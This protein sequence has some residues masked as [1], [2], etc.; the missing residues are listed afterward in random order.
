MDDILLD[1]LFQQ[2]IDSL[3]EIFSSKIFIKNCIKFQSQHFGM[4]MN[5][6]QFCSNILAN[7]IDMPG[8]FSRDVRCT[9]IRQIGKAVSRIGHI[10]HIKFQKLVIITIKSFQ[11]KLYSFHKLHDQIIASYIFAI[12]R[13]A[14][15]QHTQEIL[16]KVLEFF[17]EKSNKVSDEVLIAVCKASIRLEQD[18]AKV[19]TFLQKYSEHKNQDLKNAAEVALTK[20]K[21]FFHPNRLKKTNFNEYEQIFENG[22][23]PIV[24]IKKIYFLVINDNTLGNKLIP[25]LKQYIDGTSNSNRDYAVYIL[26]KLD[27]ALHDNKFIPEIATLCI[28]HL[29]YCQEIKQDPLK[30]IKKAASIIAINSIQYAPQIFKYFEMSIQSFYSNHAFRP[31]TVYSKKQI[32]QLHAE[33]I[34]VNSQDDPFS[35][36]AREEY[37][38]SANTKFVHKWVK[39]LAPEK[40]LFNFNLKELN[41]GYYSLSTSDWVS[42]PSGLQIYEDVVAHF[43][44]CCVN[45]AKLQLTYPEFQSHLEDKERTKE[46]NPVTWESI[47]NILGK[48]SLRNYVLLFF[49]LCFNPNTDM[50]VVQE[51]LFEMESQLKY[52]NKVKQEKSTKRIP[53]VEPPKKPP[54]NK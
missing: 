17:I 36:C 14:I 51:I 23:D 52:H 48:Y 34:N 46:R 19:F 33:V 26:A 50:T 10:K 38:L 28:Q 1:K 31:L 2:T 53:S 44:M 5:V 11:L 42:T 39:S 8:I 20:M 40:G 13:M 16:N 12:G 9:A 25:F 45:P 37:T 15:N 24:T 41:V 18:N 54:F 22:A 4:K 32:E 21:I 3:G 27:N 29:S 49:S 47:S 6:I 35:N 7:I 43:V 30:Y